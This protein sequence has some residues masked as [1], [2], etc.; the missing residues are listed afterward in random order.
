MPANGLSRGA[1]RAAHP[2]GVALAALAGLSLG[3]VIGP[4]APLIALGGGLAL[5]AADRTRLGSDPQGRMLIALAGS[6]AAI[7]TIF[8][9]P[10]VAVILLLEVVAIAGGR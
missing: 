7:A 5:L 8:G 6:A 2:P 3:A 9:N 10:L 4:E 1:D